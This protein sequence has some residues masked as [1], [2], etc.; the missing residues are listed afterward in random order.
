M[1]IENIKRRMEV[2][3]EK[4]KLH[5]LLTIKDKKDL[6]PLDGTGTIVFLSLPLNT[7]L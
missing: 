7:S 5:Y 6:A 3:N 4:Y 2:L 1:G